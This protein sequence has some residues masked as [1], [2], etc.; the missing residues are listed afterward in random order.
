MKTKLCT[1]VE[2]TV[3]DRARAYIGLGKPYHNL[4]HFVEEAMNNLLVEKHQ[5]HPV[6]EQ[7]EDP[8]DD[9]SDL[10]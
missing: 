5:D 6:T 9:D 1:T 3:A 2:R 7:L 8:Q 10:E 4:S